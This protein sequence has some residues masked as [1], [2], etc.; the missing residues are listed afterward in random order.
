MMLG[1]F[2]VE[3]TY[4]CEGHSV[5]NL[6]SP[7]RSPPPHPPALS[8]SSSLLPA[9]PRL[10]PLAPAAPRR[11]ICRHHPLRTNPTLHGIS[12]SQT[13]TLAGELNVQP[14]PPPILGPP[15]VQPPPR[16][17]ASSPPCHVV[18]QPT[19]SVGPP[20]QPTYFLRLVVVSPPPSTSNPNQATLN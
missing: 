20:C 2:V 18:P 6:A 10:P 1:E 5:P 14:W 17:W 3:S 11:R 13:L 4:S 8:P 16:P 7:L 12:T 15:I 19:S 9:P